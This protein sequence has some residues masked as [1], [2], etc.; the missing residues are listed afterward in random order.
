MS[1]V[2]RYLKDIRSLLASSWV[3]TFKQSKMA[4]NSQMQSGNCENNFSMVVLVV[5][6]TAVDG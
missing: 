4:R 2:L 6:V 1:L 5:T 3:H